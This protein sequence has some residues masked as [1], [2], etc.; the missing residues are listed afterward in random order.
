MLASRSHKSAKLPLGET[1]N[2][3]VTCQQASEITDFTDT[4]LFGYTTLSQN[5]R[6]FY[7][8]LKI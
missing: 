3:A 2:T 5:G 7:S 6:Y 4:L 1:R 8:F